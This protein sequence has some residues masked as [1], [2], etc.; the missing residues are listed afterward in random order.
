MAARNKFFIT[1]G[2]I[3]FTVVLNGSAI[4]VDGSDITDTVDLKE[5]EPGK[6]SLLLGRKVFPISLDEVHIREYSVSIGGTDYR[7]IVEDERDRLLR[8]IV[9]KTGESGKSVDILAPMPGLVTEIEVREGERVEAGM[10]LIVL[11]AMKMENE[12]RSNIPG[13]VDK[14]FI[15]PGQPVEKGYTLLTI[16]T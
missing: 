7:I 12:I 2:E 3:T 4:E 10:G 13:I 11:E 16:L 14:I 1:I 5:I 15:K 8:Q 9:T 6:Y